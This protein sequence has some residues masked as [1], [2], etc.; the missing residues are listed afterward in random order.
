MLKKI[1][2]ITLL[3]LFMS[4]CSTTSNPINQ[5]E[6]VLKVS[7]VFDDG[8]IT[9]YEVVRPIFKERGLKCGFAIVTRL[10]GVH[11][12]MNESH[13][14]NLNNDGFEILAHSVNHVNM[15]KDTIPLDYA[16]N[17]IIKSKEILLKLDCDI[18]G[19]V[20]PMSIMNDNYIPLLSEYYQYAYTKSFDK[21]VTDKYTQGRYGLESHSLEDAKVFLKSLTN[22]DRVVFY[23]HNVISGSQEERDLKE[24]LNFCI[25]N[26]Y[27]VTIPRELYDFTSNQN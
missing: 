19:W 25:T 15:S 26:E 9:D 17:E 23:A 13:I 4:F 12:R 2:A 20:T 24:L 8:W 1:L 18:K 10:I 11:N 22:T 3:A 5:N 6:S 27:Q 14:K 16:K 7:F 21:S